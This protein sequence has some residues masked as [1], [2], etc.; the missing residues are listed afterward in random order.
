VFNSTEHLLSFLC[1][2]STAA[3]CCHEQGE[4]RAAA[5]FPLAACLWFRTTV[6]RIEVAIARY[7][8]RS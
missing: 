5:L 2:L 6:V 1:V 3:H 7:G 4:E 8:S